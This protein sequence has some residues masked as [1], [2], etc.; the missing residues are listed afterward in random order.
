MAL[1][2][3]ST[4]W[5]VKGAS[6]I[7]SHRAVALDASTATK[8][9]CMGLVTEMDS[10]LWFEPQ[11]LESGVYWGVW[12]ATTTATDAGTETL[13]AMGGTHVV[14]DE[15]SVAALGNICTHPLHRRKGCASYI[16]VALVKALLGRGIQDIMLHV[17]EENKVAHELYESLGFRV[18]MDFVEIDMVPASIAGGS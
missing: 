17:E 12:Q 16:V 3:A 18:V 10:R 1:D 8:A 14:S 5:K 15:Y 11:V 4:E 6:A 13:I 2:I 9:A 7:E